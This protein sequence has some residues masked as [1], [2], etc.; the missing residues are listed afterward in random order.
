M[1]QIA[2][3]L[4]AAPPLREA[5]LDITDLAYDSRKVVPGALFFCVRGRSHDGHAWAGDAV[6]AGAAAIV[7][8]RLLDVAAPQLV[9][10]DSRA[11]MNRL[12]SPFFDDPSS[13]LQVVGI[14]G[15]NGK[16]TIAFMLEAIFRG[17]G[18]EAG[19]IGTVQ[20]R[21]AGKVFPAGRT[22]PEAIDLQRTLRQMVDAGVNRCAVEVTSIGLE[23]GRTEGIDFDVAVFTNLT[24]DHLD[25]H[26]TMD[27][28]YL[29]KRKLFVEAKPS[30]SVLNI[31]DPYG[32]RLRAELQGEVLTYGFDASADLRATDLRI[33]RDGSHFRATGR[34][35]DEDVFVRLPGGF[36]VSNSLAAIGA[37]TLLGV[38]PASCLAGLAALE[39]VPGRFERVDEGQDFL[40]LVDY[41]HTPDSLANVLTA[42]RRLSDGR[43]IAVFGCGG[44][45]DRAK[46]PVMGEVAGTHAD[47]VIATSDNPRNEDPGDILAEVEAGLRKTAPSEG[48]SIVPDRAEAIEAAVGRARSGDVVVIAGKGHETGQEFADRVIPFDDRLVAAAALRRTVARGLE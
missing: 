38:P 16:T 13:Q 48:Y 22:T 10:P 31:D 44:A 21:I 15:T 12:A 29:A 6:K 42:A 35:F 18:D 8:E 1:G 26:G 43:V 24:H 46:R 32:R 45:R 33:S 40:V 28:Y 19:L 5:A 25:H 3:V 41:A 2:A 7:C 17:A 14:T 23:E 11:A 37:A 36:N 20:T 9:V 39:A 30:H 47:I 27:R 34:G 4:G